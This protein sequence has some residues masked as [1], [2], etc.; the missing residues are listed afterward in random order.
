MAKSDQSL[1]SDVQSKFSALAAAAVDLNQVSDKLAKSVADIDSA[2]GKLNLGIRC[3]VS[4]SDITYPDG[5]TSWRKYIGYAKLKGK[6]GI[7]LASCTDHG[8]E[9][10]DDWESWP[11]NESPREMRLEAVEFIPKLLEEL[12]KE[13]AKTSQ[14]LRSKL[15]PAQELASLIDSAAQP[16]ANRAEKKGKS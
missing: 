9:P 15:D 1:P 4:Y 14:K 16:T 10:A 12:T 7:A 6:W 8:G 5:W 11:F 13:A 2:I 3:W